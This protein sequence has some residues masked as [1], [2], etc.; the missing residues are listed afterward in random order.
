MIFSFIFVFLGL[1]GLFVSKL[2]GLKQ[3]IYGI[4]WSFTL[5]LSVVLIYY[6]LNEFLSKNYKKKT[7]SILFQ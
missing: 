1:L 2:Y 3:D 6:S 5:F 7:N 4:I